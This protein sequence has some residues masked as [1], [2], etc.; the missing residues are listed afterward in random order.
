MP[1]RTSPEFCIAA[2][3]PSPS[4][5][6]NFDAEDGGEAS[7]R[8]LSKQSP[9]PSPSPSSSPRNLKSVATSL[10]V[11]VDNGDPDDPPDDV[12]RKRKA[13]R[14][15]TSA[16]AAFQKPRAAAEQDRRQSLLT[17]L[18][19][20]SMLPDSAREDP[21]DVSV[22]PSPSASLSPTA[23]NLKSVVAALRVPSDNDDSPDDAS[24]KRRAAARLKISAGVVSALQP[25]SAASEQDRRSQSFRK[26]V[27]RRSSSFIKHGTLEEPDAEDR[28]FP[29]NLPPLPLRKQ[30]TIEGDDL[31]DSG[32]GKSPAGKCSLRRRSSGKLKMGVAALAAMTALRSELEMREEE[33]EPQTRVQNPDEVILPPEGDE[34]DEDDEEEEEAER[35]FLCALQR[36][37][38]SGKLSMKELLAFKELRPCMLQRSDPV[39]CLPLLRGGPE[40]VEL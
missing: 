4:P 14:L 16:M 21:E 20:S 40:Q 33:E 11:T 13:G 6:F 24:R 3:S 19:S 2:R 10:R 17:P 1:Q 31:E 9:T 7:S 15:K 5:S 26:T 23:Q 30:G 39:V 12:S 25:P 27:R 35:D 28:L 34:S 37:Q 38:S 36:V 29:V 22:P 8:S 32:D 18:R